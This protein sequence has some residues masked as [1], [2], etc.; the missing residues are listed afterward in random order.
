MIS[1]HIQSVFKVVEGILMHEKDS[2]KET[3]LVAVGVLGKTTDVEV[4]ENVLFIFFTQLDSSS[5][6]LKGI[7]FMQVRLTKCVL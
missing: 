2:V 4:L 1:R 5:I 7:A 3:C 6:L